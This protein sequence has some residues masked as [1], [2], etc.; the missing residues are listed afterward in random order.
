M[1]KNKPGTS[2]GTSK[3]TQKDQDEVEDPDEINALSHHLAELAEDDF[4]KDT[5][6][7]IFL[8]FL[9]VFFGFFSQNYPKKGHS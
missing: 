2:K 9:S 7:E 3:E 1:K 4:A 5:V 6:K 8:D